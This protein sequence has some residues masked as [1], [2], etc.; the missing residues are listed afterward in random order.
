MQVRSM[1]GNTPDELEKLSL[2]DASIHE[3]I[4]LTVLLYEERAKLLGIASCISAI[5]SEFTEVKV[6]FD[7]TVKQIKITLSQ[8]N[9]LIEAN[10][11]LRN[12]VNDTTVRDSLKQMTAVNTANAMFAQEFQKLKEKMPLVSYISIKSR[13]EVVLKTTT[14]DSKLGELA[15]R[16]HNLLSRAIDVR[17]KLKLVYNARVK[18]AVEQYETAA[19]ESKA[20]WTQA[21]DK[22]ALNLLETTN[23]EIALLQKARQALIERAHEK[24]MIVATEGKALADD[25]YA[26]VKKYSKLPKELEAKKKILLAELKAFSKKP[27]GS[28]T[29]FHNKISPLHDAIA[30]YILARNGK[31]AKPVASQNAYPSAVPARS[32]A[33]PHMYKPSVEIA[34][35][36]GLP[37]SAAIA[38][39][40]HR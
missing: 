28:F 31:P 37:Q 9:P 35:R 23:E 39:P 27:N 26:T 13:L 21:Q 30:E 24:R 34:G 18:Q 11:E 40:T 5:H 2:D 20:L 16:F 10:S 1:N 19:A 25:L 14:D 3:E 17:S 36:P 7:E 33:S 32:A 15:I 8:I 4:V 38:V 12:V 22:A 29:D 6:R